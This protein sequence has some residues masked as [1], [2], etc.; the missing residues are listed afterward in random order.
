MPPTT[1]IVDAYCAAM[2]RRA[3]FEALE[4]GGFAATVPEAPGIVAGADTLEECAT[5][6][7]ERS[8]RW[9]KLCAAKGYPL[10]AIDGIDLNTPEAQA[11]VKYH[12]G[13][14]PRPVTGRFF[15]DENELEAAFDDWD[16]AAS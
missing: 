16:K 2:L 11:L 3:N 4:E 15:A 14:E 6:L 13:G 7:L 10:P 12:Q 5:D 1:S 9:I 8:E